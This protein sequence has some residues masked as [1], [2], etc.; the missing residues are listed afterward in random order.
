MQADVKTDDKG[1]TLSKDPI[2]EIGDPTHVTTGVQTRASSQKKGNQHVGT[3]G[4]VGWLT[5]S[6]QFVQHMYGKG[7]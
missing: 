5:P 4:T 1:N 7:L 3:V 6:L 2:E